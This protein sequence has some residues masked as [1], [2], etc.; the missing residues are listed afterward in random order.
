M[1]RPGGAPA[2]GGAGYAL[3]EAAS[4]GVLT[5][6]NAHLLAIQ[7]TVRQ[8]VNSAQVG[9]TTQVAGSGPFG[10]LPGYA[11]GGS[12]H[13]EGWALV[14]GESWQVRSRTP[15][16]LGQ[17]V[18]VLARDGLTLQVEPMETETKGE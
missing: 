17:K 15:L 16:R 13:R 6:L 8:I 9:N 2:A 4:R 3:G 12:I 5:G 10:L 7:N 14:G 11:H 18:R 1:L